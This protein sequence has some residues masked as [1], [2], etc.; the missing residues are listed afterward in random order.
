[1]MKHTSIFFYNFGFKHAHKFPTI[2]K[3][4]LNEYKDTLTKTY[5]NHL[6]SLNIMKLRSGK[7]LRNRRSPKTPPSSPKSAPF[8][9]PKPSSPKTRS[10]SAK[11]QKKPKNH[12][13]TTR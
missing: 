4:I 8:Q 10:R 12:Y 3:H 11:T 13:Y 7:V 1:M 2:P 9:S 5:N 6:V